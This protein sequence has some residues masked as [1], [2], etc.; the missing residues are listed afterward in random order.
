MLKKIILSMW[1][2]SLFGVSF[3]ISQN[4]LNYLKSLNISI[5][6]NILSKQQISRYEAARYLNYAQCFNCL[7][8]SQKIKEK[9]NY[10]WL[11]NFRKQAN[12]YLNDI[13]PKN[14]YYYCVASLANSNYI[15][16]YPKTD[17]I[18]GWDFCW[19]NSL[20]YGELLQIV[21]NI[22]SN[23]ILHKYNIDNVDNFYSNMMSIKWTAAATSMNITKN[24]YKIV[25][26][27][28]NSWLN[29][30]QI[31]NFDEFYLYEKYCNLFPQGCS[32]KEFWNIKKWNYMLSIINI[33][34]RENLLTYKEAINTHPQ[35]LIS[36]E[37]LIQWLYKVKRINACK[38]NNNTKKNIAKKINDIIWIEM[39]CYPL[40]WDA[41]LD[42]KCKAKTKWPVKKIVWTY[43]GQIIWQW[44]EIS[45]QFETKWYKK[46]TATA[47]AKDNSMATA[48]SFFKIW[49]KKNRYWYHIWLQIT[50]SPSSWPE[51]TKVT[52]YSEIKWNP[53][54]ILWN[55]G[56]GSKYK[57]K[58]WINPI[59]T[60]PKVWNYTVTAKA[61]KN[62]KVNATSST[63][64][65][66]Y[67]KLNKSNL[68]T[69][70]LKSNPSIWYPN[71][72]INFTL[73]TKNI[74]TSQVSKVIWNFGDG[75]IKTT[76]TLSTSHSFSSPWAY[77]ISATIY[78]NNGTIIPSSITQKIISDNNK[79]WAVI[80]ANTLEQNTWQPIIFKII[81]K[82]F[83]RTDIQ[84]I[85]WLYWDGARQDTDSL[86]STHI[87][88]ES[89]KYPVDAIIKLNNWNIIYTSMTEAIIW[90]K[91][92]IWLQIT[93][94]P[95]SWPRY[96]VI[97][98]IPTN[99][100][101]NF[102]FT[103]D[104]CNSCPCHF[105]SYETAFLPWMKIQALLVNPFNP[106]QIYKVSKMK[107]VK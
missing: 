35:K 103:V 87:Y 62:W 98:K 23:K 49:E 54:Y 59:K 77:P 37:E 8:P 34:Y 65:K 29:S 5:N 33:L 22:I 15:H 79:Y 94:S 19:S 84:N 25:D 26:K 66:I 9:F 81:P 32:F 20:S 88:Y 83:K 2:I 16:G 1:V 48:N 82:W 101:N 21:V 78:L 90:K 74:N 3:W 60:Y 18:C 64:I 56:D 13:N 46:I 89:N 105:A 92:H 45:H 14:K 38:I 12:F 72:N 61:Y 70:Y 71:Q 104:N 69:S 68:P 52:F 55:F 39:V 28:K 58:P 75:K 96:N 31:Q 50:P 27:I 36:W 11:S 63:I 91:N 73:N 102:T 24:S 93:P 51:W 10:W 4:K 76:S 85:T 53:D 7:N 95:S 41:P 57:K 42:T 17:P 86:N 97:N 44:E 6:K 30:Y 99:I 107:I 100:E 106:S 43:N 80:T 67:K 40:K 47:I